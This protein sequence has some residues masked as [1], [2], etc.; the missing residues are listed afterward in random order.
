MSPSRNG[1]TSSAWY[2]PTGTAI[3]TSCFHDSAAPTTRS[4]MPAGVGN[5]P[6]NGDWSGTATGTPTTRYATT[7]ATTTTHAG[8]RRRVPTTPMA[9]PRMIAAPAARKK[10]GLS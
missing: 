10:A 5:R 1:G 2:E 6:K 4:T 3:V 8:H 7:T 9:E